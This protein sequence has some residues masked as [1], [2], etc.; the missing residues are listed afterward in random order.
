MSIPTHHSSCATKAFKYNCPACKEQVWFF[1]CTCGSKVFFDDLGAP[2]P[3]HY[4]NA[5]KLIDTLNLVQGIDRM[6]EDEIYEVITKYEKTHR[7]EISEE[8][9]QI[10]EDSIGR[11]KFPFATVEVVADKA[12]GDVSGR[13]MVFNRQVNIFKKLGYDPA[14]PFTAGFLSS[15]AK[16]EYG[17][18][19]IREKP[20]KKNVSKEYHAFV[21]KKYFASKPLKQGDFILG[22]VT[23]I[24]HSKG[25]EFLLTDH[26]VY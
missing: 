25:K 23:V 5:Q 9:L 1:S 6:S 19:T 20:D 3:Q 13:I 18:I 15:L 8:M 7:V 24:E 2:W 26:K 12:I 17:E 22:T 11:R 10:V 16:G 14:S 21:S 4:C